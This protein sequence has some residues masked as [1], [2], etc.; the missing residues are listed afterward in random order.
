MPGLRHEELTRY[1]AFE[2]S[3]EDAA[4]TVRQEKRRAPTA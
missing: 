3:L 2:Q 1:L 4:P